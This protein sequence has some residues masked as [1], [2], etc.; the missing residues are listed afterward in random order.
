[1]SDELGGDNGDTGDVRLDSQPGLWKLCSVGLSFG[2]DL[3]WPQTGQD[4]SLYRHFLGHASF[5]W[6]TTQ[7]TARH[8]H[9]HRCNTHAYYQV[10]SHYALCFGSLGAAPRPTVLASPSMLVSLIK[11]L[12]ASLISTVRCWAKSWV[13]FVI[14]A[15]WEGEHRPKTPSGEGSRHFE[16]QDI[17]QKL[18]IA[19]SPIGPCPRRR[20]QCSIVY[21]IHSRIAARPVCGRHTPYRAVSQFSKSKTG[22][23]QIVRT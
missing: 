8:L 5:L 17:E 11:F 23:S 19:F 12:R 14:Q 3:I 1:M 22:L 20:L 4:L 13:F 9:V 16:G 21:S 2:S 6:N 10:D 18:F 15:P 7:L